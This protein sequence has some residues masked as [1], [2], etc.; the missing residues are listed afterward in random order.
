MF[1]VTP[2]SFSTLLGDLCHNCGIWG[3]TMAYGGYCGI[4]GLLW[5]MGWLRWHMG[6][7]VAYGGLLWHMGVTVAYGVLLWHMG[8]TVAYGGF[9]VAS[10][11]EIKV[12][13]NGALS[14]Y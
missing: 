9:T 6:V 8:V 4:W 7:T 14:A 5:H 10:P 12:R 11:V 3:V 13:H 1:R 2:A